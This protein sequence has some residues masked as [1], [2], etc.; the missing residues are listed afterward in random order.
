[1]AQSPY[2]QFDTKKREIERRRRMAEALQQQSM[3]PMETNQ[4]AGGY[5]V[6][7]NPLQGLAKMLTAYGAKKGVEQADTQEKELAAQRSQAIAEAL[8]GMPAETVQEVPVDATDGSDEVTYNRQTVRPSMA[9]YAGWMGNLGNLGPEVAQ[10]GGTM[11]NMQLQQ[12]ARAEDRQAKANQGYTLAPGALRMG[13]NNEVLASAPF[14]PD[15]P[16]PLRAPPTRQRYDGTMVI[17]EELQPDGSWKKIGT[18]PRFR[19]GPDSVTNVNVG[20]SDNKYF[21]VRR[22][23]QAKAFDAAEKAARGAANTVN[24]LDRFIAAAATGTA[25]GA[26]PIISGVENFLT[27]FGY[28]SGSLQSVQQMQQAVGS[29]LASKMAELGARGLTDKDMEILRESLPRV[30]TDPEARV[31]IA[32]IIKKEAL[33]TLREYHMVRQ[34]ERKAY[35]DFAKNNPSPSWYRPYEQQFNVEQPNSGWSIRPK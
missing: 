17:Q 6:P 26:Q 24:A 20:G 30:N 35:P 31:A 3:A 11:L 4:M 28:E 1:M 7:I 8:R 14:K 16:Q 13:P 19:Q 21:Q 34:D 2:T 12:Q 5:V 18:G 15:A 23:Q 9:D 32:N 25:G 29:I 27:T 10:M 33:N 22:E